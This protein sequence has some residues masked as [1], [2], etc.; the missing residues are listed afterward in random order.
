MNIRS[1]R[2]FS[3][4]PGNILAVLPVLTP[5]QRW[6]LLGVL[7]LQTLSVMVEVIVLG[8]FVPLI[9][10]VNDPAIIDRSR[11][12]SRL[13]DFSNAASP[14]NFILAFAVTLLALLILRG[15]LVFAVS[16]FQRRVC[17]DLAEDVGRRVL[18]SVLRMSY[19]EHARTNSSQLL[20]VAASEIDI[21]IN[22]SLINA[23][24]LVAE[25]IVTV[26]IIGTLV[27]V[28][29]AVMGPL[30]LLLGAAAYGVYWLKRV[31][32]LEAGRIMREEQ[33]HMIKSVQQSVGDIRFARLVGAESSFADAVARAWWRYTYAAMSM[34]NIQRGTRIVIESGALGAVIILIMFFVF[35]AADPATVLPTLGLLAVAT[36]RLVPGI[37]RILAFSQALRH[38]Q[39]SVDVIVRRL[40]KPARPL[41]HQPGVEPLP[42]KRRIDFRELRFAYPDANRPALDGVSLSIGA[43][44]M[45]G[46]VGPSG[47]GKSTLID[48]LCGLIPPDSGSI[49]VDG[50]DIVRNL[51]RWQRSIG[52]VPQAIYIVDD[53]I[54]ANVAFAVP[55]A[56]IDH[57]AV[58]RAIEAAS[59]G[60]F[61]D[62]L[63]DGLDTVVGERGAQLSGGQRQRIAIA[64]A[65]Y[66][67]PSILVFDEA[68][69][70]LDAVTEKTI[71][72]A[73]RDIH[74][75][76]TIVII[77]HRLNTVKGCDRLYLLQEGRLAGQ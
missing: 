54:T 7:V 17:S 36:V 46:I 3:L 67:N 55:Q 23:V 33:E 19:L 76:K 5:R 14:T 63:P 15:L 43:G 52:Y 39:T 34:L 16:A 66:R 69:S 18:L 6:R 24:F 27:A 51:A 40:N 11:T 45:I 41:E 68:T 59:L 8:L 65:L 28:Q 44:E 77:A 42:L 4:L 10:M 1:S 75:Q 21:V 25:A 9:A 2:F 22:T 64:R 47:A 38:L 49:V 57:K 32:L 37:A 50:V 29:P 13:Y 72:E 12:L 60:A 62:S 74:G 31:R 58:R 26:L 48:I 20:R 53:T 56:E 73:L 70:S 30:A 35:T 61:V 71:T